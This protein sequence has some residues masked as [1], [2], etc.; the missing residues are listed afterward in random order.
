ML[1]TS[2]H[3]N[4]ENLLCCSIN[5]STLCFSHSFIYFLIIYTVLIYL[6]CLNG[7]SLIVDHHW[8]ISIKPLM[9]LLL[10]FVSLSA[11]CVRLF[12]CIVM[13]CVMLQ[14]MLKAIFAIFFVLWSWLI[15]LWLIVA[16]TALQ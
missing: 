8:R 12:L 15:A 9:L 3:R 7:P 6:Y 5:V 2:L 13:V 14:L 16:S 1:N 4:S 11:F 10:L